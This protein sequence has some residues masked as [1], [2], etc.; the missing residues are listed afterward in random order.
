MEKAQVLARLTR[1][2]AFDERTRS[3]PYR[4]CAAGVS[5]LGG[6]GGALTLA[7]TEPQRLTLCSTT[8]AAARLEDLQEVLGEGPGADASRRGSMM[9]A[10]V[11]KGRSAVWPVFVE[12]AFAAVGEVSVHAFP[13]SSGAS[14]IGVFTVYQLPPRLLTENADIASFV[15]NSI[16]A[17]ILSDPASD[18]P[19]GLGSWASRALVHQATGMVMAQLGIHSDD[20]M[21]LLRAHAF[22]DNV[23]LTEMARS[24]NELT[25]DFSRDDGAR[26]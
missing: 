11:S 13:M 10:I 1:A 23:S 8:D 7:Y 3:L 6:D 24:V 4:L 20:A 17:A 26:P 9:S 19:E 25:F 14:V 5:L 15:A 21:A 2:V 12:A 22:A 16:G 18:T